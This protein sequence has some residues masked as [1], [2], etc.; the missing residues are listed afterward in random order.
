M[1]DLLSKIHG[2]NIHEANYTILHAQLRRR[3]PNIANDY[4]KP[5]LPSTAPPPATYMYQAPP[6]PT[7]ANTA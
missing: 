4:P 6:P 5:E 3:W 2:L 1:E 7:N